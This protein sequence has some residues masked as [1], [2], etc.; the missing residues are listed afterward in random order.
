MFKKILIYNSGGGLGDSIQIFNLILSLQNHFKSS[1]FFYL[2]AHENHF[3]NK[4]KEF[5][6]EINTLDLKLKYFGF[7]LWHF[8]L[9]RKKLNNLGI[10]KFDIIIDLQSKLRNTLIL[11][12]IPHKHFYSS[13][14]NFRFCTSK[15]NYLSKNHIKNLSIFFK[16]EIK[17]KIY[18]LN[19][20]SKEYLLEAERLL[21]NNNYIGFSMTQGN[22]YRKKSWSID[23]FIA[24]A[25]K[26]SSPNRIPVFFIKENN[27]L[28]SKIKK[29]IPNALF[30]EEDSKLSCPALVTAL[31]S[32]LIQAVTIDNGV[33][34]MMN[35]AKIPMIVLFGPTSADKFAPKNDMV[36]ILDS[37]KIYNS[38]NINSIKIEDIEKFVL[39]S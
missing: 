20:L 10:E 16:D 24:L 19:N 35:L 21:P 23:N 15:G 5:N 30:P 33:M 13:T 29:D 12:Q 6:I 3:K 28:I 38:E 25:L 32:R 22:A 18:N 9:A 8:F 39:S 36:K 2:S 14:L 27:E 1:E 4:L 17:E 7:R 11:N 31:A 26:L 37:K 34:H